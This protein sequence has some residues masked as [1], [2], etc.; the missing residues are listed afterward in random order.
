MSTKGGSDKGRDESSSVERGIAREE[1]NRSQAAAQEI[2]ARV[3]DTLRPPLKRP[4][5]DDRRP[6]KD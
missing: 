6:K 3:S 2:V 5:G 1:L 4:P